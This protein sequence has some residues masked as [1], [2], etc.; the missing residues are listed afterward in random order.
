MFKNNLLHYF[1]HTAKQ[2]NLSIERSSLL[3]RGNTCASSSYLEKIFSDVDLLKSSCKG[4]QTVYMVDFNI[5]L[6]IQY[7]QVR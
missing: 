4:F 5:L 7:D 3:K 2:G 6:L 1:T